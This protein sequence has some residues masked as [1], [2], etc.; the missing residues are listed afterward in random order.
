[1]RAMM[2]AIAQ[3]VEREVVI[4]EVAGSSPV[5]HPSD[6][7]SCPCV[8]ATNVCADAACTAP[9]TFWH[10]TGG[11]RSR[12]TAWAGAL[13]VQVLDLKGM[14]FDELPTG[15]NL[16]SHEHREQP[17]GLGSNVRIHAEKRSRGGVHRGLPE[18]NRV[19]FA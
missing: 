5:G 1:M 13:D 12:R 4:L 14:I 2:V 15:F 7:G 18:L 8:R 6:I 11:R 3:L 17:F 16:F 10:G 9:K 19:H